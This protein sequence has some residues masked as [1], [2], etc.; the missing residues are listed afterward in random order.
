M[1]KISEWT[2]YKDE[3]GIIYQIPIDKFQE[4]ISYANSLFAENKKLLDQIESKGHNE[5][6]EASP[7]HSL[8]ITANKFTKVD[9]PQRILAEEFFN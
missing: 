2:R 5:S 1:I 3:Y 4:L 9:L 6:N 8:A 7:Q